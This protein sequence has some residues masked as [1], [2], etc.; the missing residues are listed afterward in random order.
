MK[1]ALM[2][3]LMAAPMAVLKVEMMDEKAEPMVEMSAT[4]AC[5]RVD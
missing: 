3:A 4:M 1:V 2:A 5:E